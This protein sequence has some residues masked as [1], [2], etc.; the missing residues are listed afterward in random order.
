[1]GLFEGTLLSANK[2]FLQSFP[3]ENLVLQQPTSKSFGKST[4]GTSQTMIVICTAAWSVFDNSG[5]CMQLRT[6]K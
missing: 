5:G 1:L 6:M 2:G 4:F 3:M